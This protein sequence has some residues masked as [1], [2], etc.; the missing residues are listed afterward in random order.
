MAWENREENRHTKVFSVSTQWEREKKKSKRR[1]W[2][3]LFLI[4]SLFFWVGFIQPVAHIWLSSFTIK[5][6][7]SKEQSMISS[8]PSKCMGDKHILIVEWACCRWMMIAK[9]FQAHPSPLLNVDG[10]AE[11][12]DS[13]SGRRVPV[14]KQAAGPEPSLPTHTPLDLYHWSLL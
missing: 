8:T 11:P 13:S 9:P 7:A 6:T 3:H 5:N 14:T 10:S 1:K 12:P 2:A 4:I